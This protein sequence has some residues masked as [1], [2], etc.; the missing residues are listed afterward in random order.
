MKGKGL[1]LVELL[2]VIAIIAALLGL[3]FAVGRG[4]LHSTRRTVCASNIRQIYNAIQMYLSEHD[5]YPPP[6]VMGSPHCRVWFCALKPYV[7]DEQI[8]I[9]PNDPHEGKCYDS[10][11]PRCALILPSGD[12]EHPGCSYGYSRVWGRWFYLVNPPV[13][14]HLAALERKLG[15]MIEL[16]PRTIML[17]CDFCP[18]VCAGDGSIYRRSVSVLNLGIKEGQL[19]TVDGPIDL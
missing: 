19:L 11:D 10:F 1:T 7:R 9:C 5:N 2:L 4:A 13:P 3:I 18:L 12:K 17:I 6:W 8:F 16:P 14:P 15:G